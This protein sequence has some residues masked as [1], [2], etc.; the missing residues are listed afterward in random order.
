MPNYTTVKEQVE[1]GLDTIT[2][3]RMVSVRLRDLMYVHQ[4]LSEYVRFFHQPQHYPELAAVE[5]FLGTS[6]GD[7][8]MGVLWEAF[9]RKLHDMLPPEIHQAFSDGVRFENPNPPYYYE[10]YSMRGE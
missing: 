7:G 10:P 5:R 4:T 9:Y 3:D 8:A 6:D 2:P 1:F